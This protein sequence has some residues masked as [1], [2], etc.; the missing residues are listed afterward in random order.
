MLLRK[1]ASIVNSF[2]VTVLI[3]ASA[4]H[5]SAYASAANVVNM[6]A[7]YITLPNAS[8]WSVIPHGDY[9]RWHLR[10]N[11]QFYLSQSV[12]SAANVPIIILFGGAADDTISNTVKNLASRLQKKYASSGSS[13]GKIAIKYFT[14]SEE[15]ASRVAIEEHMR[16]YPS[17]SVIL[18]GHSYGGDTAYAVADNFGKNMRIELLVT[19]DPV[20]HSGI[21][22][23][24]DCAEEYPTGSSRISQQR[25]QC[26]IQR[27]QRQKPEN[28]TKWINV[29]ANGASSA[30]SDVV[31]SA[32][33][34][35]NSQ[36][37]A[38]EDIPIDLAHGEASRM[39]S[40]A[41]SSVLGVINQNNSEKKQTCQ[42]TVDRVISSIRTSGAKLTSFSISKGTANHGM[43]GNPTSRSDELNIILRDS[44]R[45]WP[46]PV[47]QSLLGHISMKKIADDIFLS[48]SN[49]AIVSFGIYQTDQAGAFFVDSNG[50]AIAGR[51][52][53]PDRSRR[54]LIKWGEV[55][56]L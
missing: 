36:A 40:K 48:C 53:D 49:T 18:V 17:S 37:N 20:G 29:W 24:Q 23:K 19:L 26:E 42:Q 28:V 14:W 38:N 15:A 21:N 27:R 16:K 10:P 7:Q 13:S 55:V 44:S 3:C 6:Q 31:S 8:N 51:C 54:S 33:E 35:W 32:G 1:M 56:C 25:K 47:S 45:P 52:I 39:Y 34:R 30:F 2:S 50:R 41:E 5:A 43:E 22:N 46:H 12:E 9:A 4:L 11:S